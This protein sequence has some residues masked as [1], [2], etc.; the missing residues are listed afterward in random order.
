MADNLATFNA[1]FLE[2]WGPQHP[3]TLRDCPDL[4][5]D[6]FSFT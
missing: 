2:I 4:Y 5:R 3:G 6:I 1:D